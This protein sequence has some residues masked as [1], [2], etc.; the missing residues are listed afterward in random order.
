MDDQVSAG[1]VGGVGIRGAQAAAGVDAVAD[2]VSGW[3]SLLV[4]DNC[5]HVL[6]SVRRACEQLAGRAAGLRLLGTSRIPL[7]IEPEC[8]WRLPPMAVPGE[9]GGPGVT[10]AGEVFFSPAARAGGALSVGAPL[11]A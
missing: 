1:L 7:D 4:I 10:E 6:E 2:A 8:V 5:E 11:P 9:A 3:R